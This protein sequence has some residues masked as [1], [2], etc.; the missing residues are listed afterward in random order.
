M[1]A[2]PR[3][4]ALALSFALPA[5]ALAQNFEYTPGSGQ[6]RVT[7]VVKATQEMMGNKQE[8]E[9][10]FDQVISVAIARAAKDTLAM[11]VVVD[12][13]TASNS[14]GM[15]M[16]GIEKI[17]GI[18]VMAKVSPNGTVYSSEGPKDIPIAAQLT[19]GLAGFLPKLRG[20]FAKGFSWTD[21]ATGKSRQFGLESD[22][23][24]ISK[25]TVVSDTTVGGEKGWR[26]DR[27]ATAA[28]SGSGAPQGQAMTM[29]GTSSGKGMI[30]VSQKGVLLGADGSEDSN[31]KVVIAASGAEVTAVTNTK[32]NI[33]KL[34]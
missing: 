12:S 8:V 30:V 22:R 21:T 29:E 1:F 26:V 15:P 3:A 34:K 4:L 25:Y 5:P 20:N 13:F 33:A 11:T 9:Q 6:Y 24:T 2:S 23:R 32:V 7:Q 16:P 17:P 19:E 27:E 14:M 31:V 28:F 18:K 10:K